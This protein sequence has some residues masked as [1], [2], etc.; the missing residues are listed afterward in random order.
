MSSREPM[1]DSAGRVF[2]GP[3]GPEDSPFV[4]VGEAPGSQEI[5]VGMPFVGPS[6][7]VLDYAL[8]VK[9]VDPT[10]VINGVKMPQRVYP[11]TY[12]EPYMTNTHKYLI[13]GEKK[14]DI[15]SKL[16]MEAR[17]ALLEEIGKYPR[18]LILAV[19]SVAL[20]A[21]LGD[22]SVKITK[23]R[24]TLYQSPLA[25]VG[26]LA[27][28]HPAYLMRGN[29][30]FRQ[31]KADI[32]YAIDLANGKPPRP[33][34]Y[35]T[36]SVVQSR[37]ELSDLAATMRAMPKGSIVGDDIETS[38]FSARMD[39]ILSHGFTMDG[40]HI[41][42]VNGYKSRLSPSGKDKTPLEAPNLIH[43]CGCLWDN[44]VSHTWH[45]GKFDIKFFHHIGQEEARVD[46]DTMLMSYSLDEQRGIHDLETVAADWLNSP[47]W[48]GVLDS[49]LTKKGMSYD[50]IPWEV[51]FQYQA[52]DIANTYR[53]GHYLKD[54]I[55]QDKGSSTQYYKVLLPSS[56][57]LVNL[58]TNGILIDQVRV[59]ENQKYFDDLDLPNLEKMSEIAHSLD[60]VQW[61]LYKD[62]NPKKDKMHNS[63]VQLGDII[64]D[65]LK[66]GFDERGKIIPRSTD[67]DTLDKVR[68]HPFVTA[69]RKHRK[70][71]KALGTYV[72]PYRLWADG[73]VIED[74]GRVHAS[75]L[76]HGTA[77]GRLASRNPNLQNIPRDPQIRGQFI[78]PVGRIFIEPDLNQAE[79]R[80]LAVLSGDPELCK[81]YIEATTSLHEVVREEIYGNPEDWSPVEVERYLQKFNLTHE[82]R[83]QGGE[84]RI[85]AE[86]KM[87]AKNVNFGI[88]Y[89]ITSVGL[90]EQIEDT[91]AEAQRMLD[92]WARKFP[93]AWGFIKS[94]RN[95]PLHGLNLITPFGYRKRFG[96]VTEANVQQ[97]GNEAANFP[98][99]N[100]ASVITMLSGVRTYKELKQYDAFYVNT[101][102]DSLLIEAPEDPAVVAAIKQYVTGVMTAIPVEWGLTRVPFQ[103]DAKYGNRWGSLIDSGKYW[104]REGYEHWRVAA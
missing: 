44:E 33:W 85:K 64:F 19:G 41:Y 53:L 42:I 94:C 81:I 79:L 11:G 61:P 14:P 55:D 90:A 95:A 5:R 18:K 103:A 52:Y 98:H 100:T 37:E 71:G 86:Q 21:L 9:Q 59:A 32:L 84:D 17:P 58:E 2:C 15:L 16:A 50:F 22:T 67:D 102:H 54:K 3:K 13:Q 76:L 10:M 83:Y 97:I 43:D 75:Y 39:K 99:Q 6:G 49:Y 1:K 40:N 51:L 47:D 45:N 96:I 29:G 24:G 31:F 8:G 48:K 7:F 77:T 23:A 4:I 35:P 56:A 63:F 87:K 73:G 66:L 12:P 91:P 28:V 34:Q 72:K 89:G 60:P 70:N 101:V 25:E 20:Q 68:P 65:R 26:I 92:A 27:C 78:S 82:N 80:S 93:V 104:K 30:S 69:L 62:I 38:G 57:Y 46:E 36:W 88:I 74:D